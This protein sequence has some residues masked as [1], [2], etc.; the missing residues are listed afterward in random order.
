MNSLLGERGKI[1]RKDRKCNKFTLSLFFLHLRAPHQQLSGPCDTYPP[2]QE[3][4]AQQFELSGLHLEQLATLQGTMKEQQ[5]IY[6]Y[7]H[8]FS[9]PQEHLSEFK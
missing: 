3:P 8:P 2:S 6:L 7:T 4:R 9:L 1:E 5:N